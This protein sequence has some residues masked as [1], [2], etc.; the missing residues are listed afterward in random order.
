MLAQWEKKLG[1]SVLI[2]G[3]V[4]LATFVLKLWLATLGHNF[5][6]ESWEIAAGIVREGKSVYANTWR[7]P[8][9]PIWAYVLGALSW[10]SDLLP[11]SSG[12]ENFHIWVAL[13]LAFVD[14]AMALLLRRMNYPFA[15]LLFLLNPCTWLITGFHSQFDQWPILVGLFAILLL[16]ADEKL[17]W[18]SALLLGLSLIIKH[19]L[20]FLPFW[21]ALHFLFQDRRQFSSA[22]LIAALPPLLF[23]CSFLPWAFDPASRSGIVDYVFKYN[24]DY[25]FSLLPKILSFAQITPLL[26]KWFA[27]VPIFSGYKLVWALGLL[28]FGWRFRRCKPLELLLLNVMVLMAFSPAMSDQYLVAPALACAIYWRS[29]WMHLFVLASVIFLVL[30]SPANVGTLPAMRPLVEFFSFIPLR[31]YLALGFFF[32]FL[33]SYREKAS[34]QFHRIYS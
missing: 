25:L 21:L 26:E 15:A 34:A 20:L 27:W 10:L 3:F 22:L 28:G 9:G 12:R 17:P 13:F 33:F 19:T 2:F 1:D 23:L 8:Y 31:R 14:I 32:L 5:D 24:S 11:F 30:Y 7:Y 18:A 16:P 29:P 4:V 6:I